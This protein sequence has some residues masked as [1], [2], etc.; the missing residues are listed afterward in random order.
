MQADGIHPNDL[1]QPKLLDNVWPSLKP[2]L[3]R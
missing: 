3:H 1:G 2:L